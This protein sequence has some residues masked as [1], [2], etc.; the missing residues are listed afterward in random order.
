MDS[1][2]KDLK[3]K[4]DEQGGSCSTHGRQEECM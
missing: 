1:L 2:N 4:E 3:V